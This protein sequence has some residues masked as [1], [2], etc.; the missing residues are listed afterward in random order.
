MKMASKEFGLRLSNENMCL[1]CY[2][3]YNNL[4]PDF[5]KYQSESVTISVKIPLL[6]L[7]HYPDFSQDYQSFSEFVR[8]AVRYTINNNIPFFKIKYGKKRN[9]SIKIPVLLKRKIDNILF[10][11]NYKITKLSLRDEIKVSNYIIFSL[12]AYLEFLEF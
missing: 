7:D 9:C 8:S 4:E 12:R 6:I 11:L 3:K 5:K 10:D 2:I 1:P